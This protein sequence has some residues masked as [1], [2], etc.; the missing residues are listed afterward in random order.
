MNTIVKRGILGPVRADASTVLAELQKAFHEFKA[1]ND[2][3][4]AEI[5]AK[6]HSDPL[7]AEKVDKIN[8][9][10]TELDGVKAELD[11]LQTIVAR[12]SYG[13]DGGVNPAVSEHTKAFNAWFRKGVDAG[14]NDLEVKAALKTSSDPDGGYVVPVEM[15]QTIERVAA[16][17]SAMRRLARVMPIGTDTYKKLVNVGGATAAWVGETASRGETSTPT[18]VEIAVNTKELYANPAATQT[19]LDDSR[20]DIATWLGSEVELAFAEQESSAFINGNGVEKPR[21]ILNYPTVAN[22]SYA[23]GSLGYIASGAASTFTNTDKLIDLQ[24]SLKAIYHSGA[25]F[26]MNTA[27]KSHMRKFKDGEGAYV[28]RL[29]ITEGA[30]DTLLG[31]P[32]VIDD[33]MPNIGAGTYPIAWGNFARSYLIVDRFGIRVLRNP[34][35]NAPYIHFYTTKRVGGGLIFYEAL[36]LLKIAAS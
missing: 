3:Q 17:V 16:T 19:L 15:E 9:H 26:L 32:I 10:M 36:K 13:G 23:W 21:G 28:F 2:K 20:V 29:G 11:K 1:E 18:L 12:G 34:Y 33:N 35:T 5:R 27:T 22:A 30:P 25:S 24:D 6:G 7:L 14:L 4:L 8:A 31:K